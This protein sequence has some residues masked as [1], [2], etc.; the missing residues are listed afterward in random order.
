M[1]LRS[2][3]FLIVVGTTVILNILLYSFLRFLVTDSFDHFEQSQ[4]SLNNTR[5]KNAVTNIETAMISQVGDWARWDSVWNFM[6]GNNEG[7]VKENLPEDALI[8]L[9]VNFICAVS[10][11]GTIAFAKGEDLQSMQPIFEATAICE[12]VKRQD[13]FFEFDSI[14]GSA[15]GFVRIDSQPPLF[16]VSRPITKSDGTGPSLGTLLFGR[17]FD[18]Q[19]I[20]TLSDLSAYPI[21]L[22][23]TR[24]TE[25]ASDFENDISFFTKG[26]DT[27]VISFNSDI[28]YG[29]TAFRDVDTNLF[30]I[31]RAELPRDIYKQGLYVISL[32]S[33]LIFAMGLIIAIITFI[34]SDVI[35]LRRLIQLNTL[36]KSIQGSD[37]RHIDIKL[38]GHDEIAFLGNEINLMLDRLTIAE[39]KLVASEELYRELITQFSGMV[40]LCKDHKII[41]ANPIAVKNFGGGGKSIVGKIVSSIVVSDEKMG[42]IKNLDKIS[43]APGNIKFG[44]RLLFKDGET[45][46]IEVSAQVIN[47]QNVETQL[48]VLT[49]LSEIRKNELALQARAQE[50]EKLNKIMIG[51]ELKMIELKEEISKLQNQLKELI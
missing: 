36:V 21:E 33:I 39:R 43:S 4:V 6:A 49:D 42:F 14:D 23:D 38:S 29:Y 5:V 11:S 18:G 27:R 22:Y 34:L 30:F 35:I 26:N 3:I 17:F 32:L 24:N 2:K 20:K 31:L 40:L 45:R 15:G 9:G 44:T 25:Q 13:V 50:L 8:T 1:K 19:I 12:E 51:R 10:N 7:F 16:V 48:L 28:I 47:Y 41:F 46:D 37:Y